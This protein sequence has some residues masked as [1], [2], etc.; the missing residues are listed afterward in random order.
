[1]SA[2]ALRTKEYILIHKQAAR[3]KSILK[4]DKLQTFPKIFRNSCCHSFWSQ[5]IP[6][7]K[8]NILFHANIG[9]G[10]GLEAANKFL[11]FI[12]LRFLRHFHLLHFR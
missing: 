8:I 1:M 4:L 9:C 11:S 10:M 3:K 5:K 2:M 12:V 6:N 7:E